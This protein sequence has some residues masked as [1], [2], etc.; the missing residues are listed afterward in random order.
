[1]NLVQTFTLLDVGLEAYKASLLDGVGRVRASASD[2]P[3][4]DGGYSGQF[5]DYDS[6]GR[7][8]GQS[9]PTETTA[10][11]AWPAAGDDAPPAG[12]GWLYTQQTYDWQGRPSVT[13]N[14]DGTTK[15]A[16]YSGCG[17]AGGAVVTLTDEGTIDGG[18]AK[19]RQQTIYSDVLGRTVKSEVFNWEGGSVY[20]ATVNTYNARDQ[21]T[22]VR[23]YQ[24]GEG[25]GTFQD[26]IM[27][28]DGHGRLK[29]RH[30]PQQDT[31]T[32][33]VWDYNP[34]DTL[35]KITDARNASQTFGYNNNRHLV[36]SITYAWPGGGTVP[37]PVS[38]DYD[39]AGNR[40]SM[41]DGS[42]NCAYGF[43]QLSRMN[44]ET[45]NFGNLGLTGNYTLGYDYTLGGALKSVTDHTNQTIDYG[46]D[47]AGRLNTITGTNY[48]ITQFVDS[49]SY[50]AWGGAKQ[51]SY[52]NGRNAS[53]GYNSRLMVSHFEIPTA[54]GL[55]SL[56]SIDYQ[57]YNDG[58]LKYSHD[59]RDDRFDR[60][61]NYDHRSLMKEALSGAEARG[62]PATTD[63]PYKQTISYDAFDH[64]TLRSSKHWSRTLPYVSSDSYVN[65][66]R[67]GWSYDADGNLTNNGSRQYTY[68]AAGR[69]IAVSGGNLGQYF[70][71]DGQR[72]K[73]T[74][75]NIV[76][77]YVRSTVLGGSVIA[78]LDGSG[79]KQRGFVYANGKVLAEQF[80]NGSLAFVHEDPSGIS[81]RR[82]HAPSGSP[83]DFIELDPFGAEAYLDD[84]YIEDPDFDGRGEGGPV[85]PGYGNLSYP[86]DG[87]T[88]DGV[89][90]PCEMASRAEGMGA[91]VIGPDS[92]TRYNHT[93]QRFEH[94]RAFVDGYSGWLP[95][96]A[97][98]GGGG[99]ARLFSGYDYT[100]VSIEGSTSG[101]WHPVF[102]EIALEQNPQNPTQGPL[103]GVTGGASGSIDPCTGVKVADLNYSKVRDYGS[104]ANR[105]TE[106]A[107]EHILKNHI[108][109]RPGK[110]QYE[111]DPPQNREAMFVQVQFYN[112]VTFGLGARKDTFN[113]KGQL[114]SISFLFTF[115][116]IAPHRYYGRTVGEGWIGRDQNG[117]TTLFNTLHLDPDCKTVRNSYPG[118]PR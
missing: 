46:Y 48:S 25:S 10:A 113:K 83:I 24:G 100:S 77:Y 4:S 114:D 62:E 73:T 95:S 6:M 39:A 112:A 44:S 11:G 90:V 16:S 69:M 18:V 108:D 88:L 13:T 84:P 36:S 79:N 41:A 76:T 109:S 2:L 32:S 110:S 3:G 96:G 106:S 58:R 93:K 67:N 98:Y 8:A 92:P 63:R 71:G 87:C 23:Q 104:G 61:Y 12:N 68:D 15:E 118:R 19:R 26:T 31:G 34:D 101:G 33:T 43:D 50:R 91:A 45:H 94:F 65:N 29:T 111:T 80:Q 17:C 52:G 75:P 74:E 107:K 102:E 97:S 5:F 60:A 64:I 115:P 82:T 49:V 105:V 51:V 117:N 40:T 70:D 81:V 78:E 99:N 7:L 37:A 72:V 22:Q 86:S 27:T 103:K 30:V 85:Y 89:Y 56:M 42:G 21:I 14:T 47:D 28:Y 57:H 53:M 66:R 38:F 116:P 20:S 1:M 59:L 35:N 9:N 54:G 55:P